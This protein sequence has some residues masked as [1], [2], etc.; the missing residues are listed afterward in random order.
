MPEEEQ[1]N[2]VDALEN[3]EAD[4]GYDEEEDEVPEVTE[5]GQLQFTEE[6][7]KPKRVEVKPTNE[8][9]IRFKNK[10]AK[11]GDVF[12]A[13]EIEVIIAIIRDV[14]KS[15]PQLSPMK[16]QQRRGLFQKADPYEKKKEEYKMMSEAITE[17]L[18]V[19]KNEGRI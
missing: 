3:G 7:A 12:S 16:A 18:I 10:Y 9:R 11:Y 4:F 2:E 8:A 14:V 13:E 19:L 5:N 1:I 6:E 17:T 15:D